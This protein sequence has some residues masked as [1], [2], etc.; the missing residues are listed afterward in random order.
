VKRV[1]LRRR[2]RRWR[3]EEI[4]RQSWRRFPLHCCVERMQIGI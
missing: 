4:K 1:G 3:V 2:R